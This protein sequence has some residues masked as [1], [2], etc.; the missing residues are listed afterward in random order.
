M[1]ESRPARR[2]DG[3]RR[4]PPVA[5]NDF[6]VSKDS[7]MPDANSNP[8]AS[9]EESLL[10]TMLAESPQL[11]SIVETFVRTLPDQVDAMRDALRQQ[12]YDRLQMLARRLRNAGLN[13]GCKA[14]ADRAAGIEQAAHDHVVDAL[15][16]RI[17]ELTEL[18][19]RI[20]ITLQ[21]GE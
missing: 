11:W 21:R 17:A 20:Q 3:S 10:S 1:I 19:T 13:N 18:V 15:S 2:L 4:F 12:S 16:Q 6:R 14:V 9:N 5:Q 8:S 7:S